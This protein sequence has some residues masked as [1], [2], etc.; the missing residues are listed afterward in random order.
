MSLK[1]LGAVSPSATTNTLLLE[2]ASGKEVVCNVSLCNR[3]SSAVTIRLYNA[4]ADTPGV[5]DALEYD[6]S[7]AANASMQRTGIHAQAGQH[8][9]VYA[10]GTG[11]SFVCDGLERDAT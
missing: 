8:I 3:N 7:L 10:S 5:E 6:Y 11:V 2:V 4:E 9:V 1:K